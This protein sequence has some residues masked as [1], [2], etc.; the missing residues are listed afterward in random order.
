MKT[1]IQFLIGFMTLC[2]PLVVVAQAPPPPPPP[3]V[4]LSDGLWGILIAGSLY[5]IRLFYK[6]KKRN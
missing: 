1:K 2:S 6:R 3:P 5:G 4:P